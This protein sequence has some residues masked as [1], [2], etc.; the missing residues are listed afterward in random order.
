MKTKSAIF[1]ILLIL[2]THASYAQAIKTP[3]GFQ[4]RTGVNLA[5]WLSQ[6]ENRGLER[7]QYIL[8][9]DIENISSMGFDHIRLPIDEVQFWDD[10]GKIQTD[11]FK[12]LHNAIGWSL[13]RN[14]RVIVDLHIIRSHY[15]NAES[16]ALWTDPKE[17][18]KLVGLWEQLSRE[19]KKYP[20]DFIAYELM[21]EAVADDNN[22]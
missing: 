19:L 11:A 22:D 1:I 10:N 17:Q 6:S 13:K 21:N 20:T 3:N 2:F 9:S 16:N 15:F 8:E 7:E 14:L 18:D 5:L 4:L 12:L